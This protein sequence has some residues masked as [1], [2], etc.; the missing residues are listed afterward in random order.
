MQFGEGTEYNVILGETA[1]KN[2]SIIARRND[3]DTEC[4]ESGSSCMIHKEEI[5]LSSLFLQL[6]E[7]IIRIVGLHGDAVSHLSLLVKAARHRVCKNVGIHCDDLRTCMVQH[8]YEA[9]RAIAYKCSQLHRQFEFSRT[10]IEPL[11]HCKVQNLA[12]DIANIDE[13]AMIP[14]EIINQVDGSIQGRHGVERLCLCVHPFHDMLQRCQ[15]RMC[16]LRRQHHE[17]EKDSSEISSNLHVS[18]NKASQQQLGIGCENDP[19]K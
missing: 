19:E 11:L 3:A 6:C 9:Q 8:A 1:N 12:L 15:L 2:P 16:R 4:I 14:S 13:E 18:S 17:E 10:V 7:H 5:N